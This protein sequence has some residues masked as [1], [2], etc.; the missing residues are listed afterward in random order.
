MELCKLCCER[1]ADKT[2][3]HYLTDG[4]IRSCLNEAGSNEREKAMAFNISIDEKS[5]E[6]RFQRNTSQKEILETF[7]RE[8]SEEEIQEAKKPMFSVDHVFCSECEKKFT[9][10]ETP[11]LQNI[12][13]KLRGRDFTG[14]QEIS[15]N[16][17]LLREFFLL[18]VYRTAVCDSGYRLSER[19]VEVLRQYFNDPQS[20]IKQLKSMPL[21]VTYLN[22][23]GEA[24]EYTTNTVGIATQN[25]N[26][27]IL[28]NDFIIQTSSDDQK[29]YP[30]D[31]FGLNS[32]NILQEFTNLNEDGFRIRILDNPQRKA[33]FAEYHKEKAVI[34]KNNYRVEFSRRFFN[35]YGTKPN[36]TFVEEF[37]NAV[38]HSGE[39]QDESKYSSA[40]FEKM[41]AIYLAKYRPV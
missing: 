19:K 38:I 22:T 36:P 18:Q 2:N 20:N 40:H 4:V 25:N 17:D 6:A 7:G 9:L 5:I 35:T 1:P 13:P 30:I 34:F 33:L 16:D 26:R 29:I 12:L 8:A 11:F 14:Q 32:G 39:V 28:F 31:F 10:I 37:V 21:Q 41:C 23:L 24:Y 27:S 3:T 15:F